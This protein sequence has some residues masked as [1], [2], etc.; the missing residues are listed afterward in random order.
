MSI[1]RISRR[2]A[3][4]EPLTANLDEAGN[5]GRTVTK[6]ASRPHQGRCTYVSQAHAVKKPPSVRGLPF[7]VILKHTHTKE[8][9]PPYKPRRL[10]QDIQ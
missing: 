3:Q 9:R 4:L 1:S 2:A 8:W 7:V 10:R 5:R 6:L